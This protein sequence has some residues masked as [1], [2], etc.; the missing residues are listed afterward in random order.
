MK[1]ITTGVLALAAALGCARIAA[2][3]PVQIVSGSLEYSRAAG[4]SPLTL[5]GTR[6]FTFTGHTGFGLFEPRDCAFGHCVDGDVVSLR[7]GWSGTD[8]GGMAT[9]DGRTYTSVGSVSADSSLLANFFGS[10]MLPA[11][12]STGVRTVPFS[13]IGQFIVLETEA[14]RR[15]DLSGGG[16]ATVSFTRSAATGGWLVNS[17]RYEFEDVSAAPE[18]STLAL[19]GLGAAYGAWRRRRRSR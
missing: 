12:G 2:A 8:L 19:V 10:V 4:M 14:A 17:L 13:F 18:P 11:G 6:D 1:G 7:A 16:L 9:V 5:A 3:D 15:Y